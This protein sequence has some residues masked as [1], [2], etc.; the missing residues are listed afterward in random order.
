M[1]RS[2]EGKAVLVTGAGG[3]I[4]HAACL[5]LAARGARL[6]VSDVD[7]TKGGE[8]AAAVRCAGGTADYV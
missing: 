6:I 5:V 3:G 7:P 4:G 2:L 8:T 1:E